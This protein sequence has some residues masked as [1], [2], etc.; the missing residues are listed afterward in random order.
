MPSITVNGMSCEH[1]RKSVKEAIAAVPGVE[2]VE[3]SLAEKKATWTE[4]SPVNID[5][6]RK[7]VSAVGF[8]P[9]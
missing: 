8:D 7:A 3:V 5:A 4:K 6:V 2:S 9:E 1:C